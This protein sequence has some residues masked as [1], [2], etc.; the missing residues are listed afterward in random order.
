MESAVAE[1]LIPSKTKQERAVGVLRQS[2]YA[3]NRAGNSRTYA[4]DSF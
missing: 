1:R 4:S 3:P 2:D